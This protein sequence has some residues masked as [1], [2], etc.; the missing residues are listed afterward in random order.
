MIDYLRRYINTQSIND[1]EKAEIILN[2][3][4]ACLDFLVIVLTVTV[5]SSNNKDISDLCYQLVGIFFVDIIVRLY[6]IYILQKYRANIFLKEIIACI[7][8]ADLFYLTFSLFAQ[9]VKIL[10]IKAKFNIV[11]PCILYVLVF[12]SYEK[13]ISYHPI[14]FNSYIISFSSLILLTQSM[15]SIIYIYYVYDMFKEPVAS[16]VAEITKGEKQLNIVHKFI[17]G[18]PVACLLLFILHYLI[19][20][21]LLFF[22]SPLTLLYGTIA[23]NI[24]KDGAKY[25]VFGCCE[26][27]VYAMINLVT[28]ETRKKREGD[29]V[30]VINE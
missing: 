12:F 9:I 13:I 2:V 30:E 16:V 19:K 26:I 15:F 10:K 18:A 11:M 14:T 17:L 29:E 8:G 28:N 6:H 22:K 3:L 4:F 1:Y 25:F 24:F 7:F 27:F 20:I 21:W 5:F 23:I